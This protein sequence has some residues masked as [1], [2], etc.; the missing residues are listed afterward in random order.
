MSDP[1][2]PLRLT[3]A[4]IL[5]PEG[6]VEDAL[7]IADGRIADGRAPEVDL[8]GLWLV[9]G[10]VDLHGDA[11]ERHMAP[12][13]GVGFDMA[14]GFASVDA[15]LCAHGVTTAYLAQCFSWEGGKRGAD[16]AEALIAARAAYPAR[17]DIR[18]Q[19][20]HETHFLDG[21]ARLLAAVASG[22]V[23]YV[24]FNDHLPE[25][26]AIWAATPGVVEGWAAQSGRTGA[27]HMAIVEAAAAMAPAVPASLARIAAGL[28]A[29]GAAMGSHDDATAA[30]RARFR[31][32]GARICEFPTTREAAAA[33]RAAGDPVLMGAPNVVRG[34]SQSGN[35]AAEALVADGLCDALVSDYYYP[36]LAAAVWALVD[37]GVLDFARAWGLVSMGPARVLGLADRGAL[38]PGARADLVAIDPASR[39]IEATFAAGRP[40]DLGPAA[41]ARFLGAASAGRLAAE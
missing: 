31:A 11:F 36:A 12:R 16:Y 8:G 34:G 27:E 23:G 32:L 7:T 14:L 4:R 9:P 6:L 2:P 39:R 19:L 22:A 21:E 17:A 41:A 20:R 40:V 18:L 28:R 30:T 5:R 37:R 26:R 13:S 3:G 25:A 1:A 29:A 15:E 35:V 33:A 10:I 24:V 38:V